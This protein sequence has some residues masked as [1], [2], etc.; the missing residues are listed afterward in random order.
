MRGLGSIIQVCSA[1]ERT[2]LDFF[3][4]GEK[5]GLRVDKMGGAVLFSCLHIPVGM[6]NYATGVST[7]STD[8]DELL[9]KIED[10]YT[11]LNVPP[12]IAITPLSRPRDLPSRLLRRGYR[13][14]SVSDVM[15]IDSE[16][17]RWETRSDVKVR[18]VRR[19]QVEA[20]SSIFNRAFKIPTNLRGAFARFWRSAVFDSDPRLRIYLA[21]I[22]GKPAGVGLIF[23]E[24]QAAGLYSVATKPE[25]R[26][27]GGATKLISQAVQDALTSKAKFVYL[28]ASRRSRTSEKYRSL[29][30]T[31]RYVRAV[32]S[33]CQSG[34]LNL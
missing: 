15:T 2:E 11:R 4:S 10:F 25:C 21:T 32:Y 13:E 7:R 5:Q 12:R 8:L 31:S 6:L 16:V 3:L 29:G 1:V 22:R 19:G 14:S 34:E 33:L 26:G 17:T 24:R 30:F 18:A 27:R 9:D 20:F 23:I 28:Y